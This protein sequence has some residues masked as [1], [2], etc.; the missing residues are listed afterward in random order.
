MKDRVK[1]FKRVKA[2]SIKPHPKNWREHPSKQVSVFN[3]ILDEVGFAD[4]LIV[5]ESERYGGL[6]LV[7]GHMRAGLLQSEVVPVIVLDIDDNE[8]EVLLTSF[9]PIGEMST[10]NQDKLESLKNDLG[11]EIKQKLMDVPV[12]NLQPK[13]KVDPKPNPKMIECPHCGE[14]FEL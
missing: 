13:P 11:V 10:V 1:E 7:D 12:L 4:V 6:V 9:D 3:E 5:Y 8:A 2:S 14:E